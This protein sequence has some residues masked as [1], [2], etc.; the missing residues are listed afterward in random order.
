MFSLAGV[1]QKVGEH[2]E[3]LD[4]IAVDIS[5][6]KDSVLHMGDALSS[7]SQQ[8]GVYDSKLKVIAVDLVE[9][10][11]AIDQIGTAVARQE[12]GISD[13]SNRVVIQQGEIR[14]VQAGLAE[15]FTSIERIERQVG[16]NSCYTL[17]SA[18]LKSEEPN[19]QNDK[20]KKPLTLLSYSHFHMK[21]YQCVWCAFC[22]IRMFD[23]APLTNSLE[24]IFVVCLAIV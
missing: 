3:E 1:T 16:L 6:T 18:I 17:K 24:A 4:V 12:D 7:V 15:A 5:D 9:T 21:V 13:L 19:H 8:V 14:T 22:G 2:D 23:E 11:G 10:K 20:P